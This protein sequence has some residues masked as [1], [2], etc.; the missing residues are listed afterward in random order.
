MIYARER[1]Y[2]L[3][4]DIYGILSNTLSSSDTD[5]LAPCLPRVPPG[6]RPIPFVRFCN[7]LI[8]IGTGK[9]LAI[10]ARVSNARHHLRDAESFS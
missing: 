1:G 10:T 4:D 7:W 9:F 3:M 2:S 5:E 8:N 6:K